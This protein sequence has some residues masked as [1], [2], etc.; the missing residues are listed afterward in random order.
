MQTIT[1]AN[2]EYKVGF[3]FRAIK[4]YEDI[5]KKSISQCV[6]TWD[7]L[8]FFYATL[9]ALNPDFKITF[10]RFTEILDENPDLLTTFQTMEAT[11]APDP[12]PAAKKKLT[13]KTTFMLWM[14]LALLSVSPVLVPV[15]SGI[16]W[17]G[18]SILL[19]W[20][21][22]KTIGKKRA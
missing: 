17:I 13:L 16:A 12:Q 9:Q 14:L 8:V 7:N 21:L 22:I 18:A 3:S 19:L 15:I 6:T 20:K 1:I 2:K 10:E 4:N 11:T 5:T